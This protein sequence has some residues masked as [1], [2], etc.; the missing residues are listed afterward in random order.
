MDKDT[1]TNAI[2][3]NKEGL[4][5]FDR[6]KYRKAADSFVRACDLEPDN[7]LYLFNAGNAF[8]EEA[9]LN[10][11]SC[12]NDA[13]EYLQK[14]ADLGS[15]P[16]LF[17]LGKA[18]D[19]CLYED[20]AV[21]SHWSKAIDYY[22]A[23]IDRAQKEGDRSH[24]STAL[25]NIGCIYGLN[26]KMYL[27]AC[28][29]TRAAGQSGLAVGQKN[30][31]YFVSNLSHEDRSRVETVRDYQDVRRILGESEISG[32][33][34]S[35]QTSSS[36]SAGL[37]DA[38]DSAGKEDTRSLEERMAELNSLVG[39]REVKK[40]V[41]SLINLLQVSKIRKERGL[42]VMPVSMHLVFTGNP[43]TGKTTVARMLAGIYREL[44]ILSK[45]HLVE[46]D[47]SEMVAGYV[48]QTAIKTQDV[49]DQA[50]GGILFIDEAYTLIKEGN[51]FGQEAVDTLLKEMEDNRD[52]LVV[53]VAGYT[54]QME[55]F[56]NSNPGLRSRFNKY[57][58]FD[59]YSDEELLKIF[60]GMCE[61]SGYT[62]GKSVRK[63]VKADFGRMKERDG[64]RFANGR[65][66][67]NYFEAAVVNQANRLAGNLDVSDQELTVLKAA[68]FRGILE[69]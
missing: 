68:D 61:K 64:E 4:R 30:Y 23:Y 51:D 36:A 15:L 56:L 3:L 40:E 35:G 42:K 45:G 5:L 69:E 2:E 17:D 50:K 22:K 19:P 24:V 8:L 48:G 9:V 18:Y 27:E 67:R 1:R 29:Y 12:R 54:E 14:A 46:V 53:I 41:S 11:T 66:V 37:S 62:L 13:R 59:D 43:G 10:H 16:A 26:R 65:S 57:I 32:S 34:V 21:T 38:G 55:N 52:N 28:C 7:S 60:I 63:L 39:L 6:K 25:N 33:S 31:S 44:G 47:R 20:F 49:I 58:H